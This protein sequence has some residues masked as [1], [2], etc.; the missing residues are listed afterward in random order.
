MQSANRDPAVFGA[1]IGGQHEL[2][3]QFMKESLG[4]IYYINH[5]FAT[6]HLAA[7]AAMLSGYLRRNHCLRYISCID[8][9]TLRSMLAIRANEC[10]KTNNVDLLQKKAGRRNR[11]M[12][13]YQLNYHQVQA[14]TA[15]NAIMWGLQGPQLVNALP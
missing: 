8:D 14:L 10:D 5:N 15:P 7:N 6:L 13:E 12:N 2:L 11:I 3:N 4:T 9:P 1:A